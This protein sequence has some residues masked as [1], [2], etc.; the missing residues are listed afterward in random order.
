MISADGRTLPL[1]LWEGE[2]L[3]RAAGW[4]ATIIGGGPFAMFLLATILP[5]MPEY[6]AGI[7]CIGVLGGG[8][9]CLV[10]GA[11]MARGRLARSIV[12]TLVYAWLLVVAGCGAGNFVAKARLFPRAWGDLMTMVL[13]PLGLIPELFVLYAL[14]CD[15]GYAAFDPSRRGQPLATLASV[16]SVRRSMRAWGAYLMVW[17]AALSV[18]IP[19]ALLI[20]AATQ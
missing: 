13:F 1:S 6:L 15:V 5:R 9:L 7:A 8:V 3:V 4:I 2:V 19:M 12:I 14:Q 11:V 10:G 20:L 17:L 16:R 18:V